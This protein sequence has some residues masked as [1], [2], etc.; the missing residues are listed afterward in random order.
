MKGNKMFSEI[1]DAHALLLSKGV[2]KASPVYTYDGK[3]YA[4]QGTGYIRLNP[5]KS[6]SCSSVTWS[7]IYLPEGEPIVSG[8]YLVRSVDVQQ[9]AE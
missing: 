4:K 2:Y 3:L 7:E 8:C 6:T 1:T 5:S 9:A